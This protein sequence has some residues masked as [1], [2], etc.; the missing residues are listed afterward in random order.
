[1]SVTSYQGDKS[2]LSLQNVVV[3]SSQPAL[4]PVIITHQ[5]HAPDYLILTIVGFILC[6]FFG[7]VVGMLLLIPSLI[8][9]LM[10]SN[11]YLKIVRLIVQ[12]RLD[13]AMFGCLG[14]YSPCPLCQGGGLV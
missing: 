5:P 9:S 7:G 8:C 10:V 12:K 2:P 11:V 4:S 13:I 3:V 1:M 14:T 6:F